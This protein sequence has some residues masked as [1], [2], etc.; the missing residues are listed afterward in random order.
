M[1]PAGFYA[2]NDI[3][4]RVATP[5]RAIDPS[6]RTVTLV[7]DETIH[8]DR[9]RGPI[10]MLR[11]HPNLYAD[12]AAYQHFIA[13]D[14]PY[15]YWSALK[16]VEILVAELGADRIIWGTDWP[17]LGQQ[18]YPELIRAIREAPFLSGDQADQ[19]LGGNALRLLG[20]RAEPAARP[21]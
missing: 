6:A 1:H 15:P 20:R 18:P 2:A 5:V 12:L 13:P 3:D 8:Y 7:G 21:V 4:L 14:E 17:Y 16:I 9:L 11:P 10:D 19:I